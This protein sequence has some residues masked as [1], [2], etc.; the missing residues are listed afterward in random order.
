MKGC[1]QGRSSREIENISRERDTEVIVIMVNG[2]E[3]NAVEDI[4]FSLS[5]DTV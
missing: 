4:V 3:D 5:W 1:I 2:I